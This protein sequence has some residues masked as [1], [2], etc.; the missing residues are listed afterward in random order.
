MQ[1][2]ALVDLGPPRRRFKIVSDDGETITA[3]RR[4]RGSKTPTVVTIDLRRHE[5]SL[6]QPKPDDTGVP[7]LRG[8]CAQSG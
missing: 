8:T 4:A 3:E 6:S 1:A 2:G 5:A 7:T